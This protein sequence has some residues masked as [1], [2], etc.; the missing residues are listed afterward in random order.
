MKTRVITGG[1]LLCVLVP[2]LVFSNQ[3]IPI[4]AAIFCVG[5]MFEL[6]RVCGFHKS[7]ALSAPLYLLAAFMPLSTYLLKDGFRL[8]NLS[9]DISRLF[10]LYAALF[11][12]LL[13]YLFGVAVFYRNR[14]QFS[15]FSA[16][17]MFGIYVLFGFTA[18]CILRYLDNGGAY[19][20]LLIFI[21]AWITDTFAYFAGFF[22]GKHKLIPEISP[23]KTVEGSIG[24]ILGCTLSFVVWGLI[25]GAVSE[26]TVHY[27]FLVLTGIV[28]SVVSQ[29]GDLIASLLKRQH[30]IKDFSHLFPG[31]GGILDRFDS[32]IAVASTLLLLILFSAVFK[33][34]ILA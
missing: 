8:G 6:L 23:K 1:A 22:F 10:L 9:A 21:G 32:I 18:V 7:V 2:I 26:F 4:A 28:V 17:F 20:Y 24:G 19:Y 29:I 12:I 25:V 11:L 31:H 5:A 34:P 16:L 14:R 27:G 30:G 13:L 3:I 33:M 15:D